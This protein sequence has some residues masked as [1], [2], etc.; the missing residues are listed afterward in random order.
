[1]RTASRGIWTRGSAGLEAV[2]A[3]QRGHLAG[4]VPVCLAIGIGAWFAC[5]TEPTARVYAISACIAALLVLACWRG[6][7]AMLVMP[8]LGLI[9]VIAGF[10]LAG[11]RGHAVAAPVLGFRFYGPI[12]GRVIKIDRARSDALRLTL[13]RVVLGDLAPHR[14]PARVRLSL[15]GDQPWIAPVPGLRVMM[16]GHLSPPSGPVEPGDFDFRRRAWFDRL[17]AVGYTRTPVLVAAE[18]RD[19]RAGL[20]VQRMRDRLSAAIRDRI[21]G[22]AGGFA[23][24]VT[25]GDRSGLGQAANAAMRESNLYHLV[26]ISGMHMAML[27]GFVFWLIRAAVALVPPLALRLPGR[28]VAAALALPA[29]AVYLLLAGGAVAT[30][31]AFVMV[32]VALVAIL[33]DRRPISLRAVAIAA[34][35]VLGLRPETLTNPGFQMSF[36]AVLGLTAVFSRLPRS[37]HQP[38]GAWRIAMPVLMLLLSSLVAGSATA[39]FAAAHFN[40]IAH[41]GLLA[42][43]LAVP[44]MGMLVMP[45]AVLLAITG[46]LGLDQ[47][48]VWMIDYG[49]RWI[50]WVAAQVSQIGGATSPVVTPPGAVLPLVS[51]GGLWLILW[52]GRLRWAGLAPGLVAA[53]LWAG[54]ERP[55]LLVADSGVLIGVRT[56]TGRALSRPTG[57]GYAAEGWLENDGSGLTQAEAHDPALLPRVDRVVRARLGKVEIRQVSGKTALAALHGCGGA[58]LLI[59]NRIDDTER[60]CIVYDLRALRRSG[61]LAGW[62]DA[63]GGLR[64]ETAAE[65]AGRRLWT[66]PRLRRQ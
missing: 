59:L 63:A 32:A 58:D 66:D 2:L 13:D 64:I 49:S 21:A 33:F 57:D 39:P 52:H 6:R 19:G 31:R 48:A 22:E 26:S 51:L 44:A 38:R 46:P 34:V 50:L 11:M 25:T 20:A 16:T 60:P 54:A 8:T 18:A 24:A 41:Y 1:M 65:R 3:R 56:D 35:V 27:A 37:M 10:G 36:A 9:L 45:G 7:G 28:K 23:A 30:E 62:L 12:E 55:D 4:W 17:G 5:P 15:H 53:W 43:L 61:A 40:R 29:S 42:N 14:T 47:P